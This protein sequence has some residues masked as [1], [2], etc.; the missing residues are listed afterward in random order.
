MTTHTPALYNH[1]KATLW[2]Y[3]YYYLVTYFIGYLNISK[4]YVELSELLFLFLFESWRDND[5]QHRL[6]LHPPVVHGQD[7]GK[8]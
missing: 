8:S 2:T 3:M 7:K 4:N 1:N 5:A 6:F